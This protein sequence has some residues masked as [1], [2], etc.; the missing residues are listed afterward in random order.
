MKMIIAIVVL[1]VGAGMAYVRLAPSDGARW[2]RASG[3]ADLGDFAAPGGFT[4]R[5]AMAAGTGGAALEKLA[6][7]AQA[8][9]RT[10]V[11]AGSVAEG[12]ITFVTRSKLFGF[13]D[14]TTLSLQGDVL[15]LHARLRFGKSDLGVN[16]ARV[17]AWL[18]AAGLTQ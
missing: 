17:Q 12:M 3:L 11:L 14:Y 15:E 8:T 9:P 1:V 13:P 7:V 5:R 18:H 2:H 4:H 6:A 16:Q 10:Q